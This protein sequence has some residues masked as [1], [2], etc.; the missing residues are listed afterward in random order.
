VIRRDPSYLD[1]RTFYG[2]LTR[3]Y[4]QE[5][6][7]MFA[8]SPGGKWREGDLKREGVRSKSF[9]EFR[10]E[11]RVFLPIHSFRLVRVMYVRV[12]A[13]VH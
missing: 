11:L 6:Q 5:Q 8:S 4:Q 10:T 9:P 1:S 13:Y 7:S 3:E 2:T 12:V